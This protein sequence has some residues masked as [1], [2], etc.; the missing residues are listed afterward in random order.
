MGGKRYNYHIITSDRY[1]LIVS[2]YP[3]IWHR[4]DTNDL[5][6]S[7]KSTLTVSIEEAAKANKF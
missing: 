2:V 7:E 3:E 5:Q 4:Y 1:W 6:S